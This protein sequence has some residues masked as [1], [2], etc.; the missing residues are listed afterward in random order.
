MTR[1]L[2]PGLVLRA[3]ARVVYGDLV[4]VIATSVAFVLASLPVVTLGA[5][6]LALVDTWTE[7]VTRRDT[8]A[9]PSER[10]R[11]R[12]FVDAYRRHLRAGVPYSVLFVVVVAL[13]AVYATFGVARQSGVFVL[14]AIVGAYV[15][16]VATVWSLRAASF[17]TREEPPIPTRMAFERAGL[18]LVDRPAFAVV[19]STV[20][21][22]VLV[23]GAALRVTF[24]LLVPGV[25]AVLE[26]VA[27]EEHV[28]DGAA[29]VRATYRRDS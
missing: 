22:V 24:P 23:G 20:A 14:A 2:S 29:A 25:L 3:V 13:T 27:F 12:V 28:G 1:E 10:G 9:P 11:L 26:V 16:V 19:L 18:S 6:V 7:V 8:G 5:A 4:T 21:A 15:V 17:Q